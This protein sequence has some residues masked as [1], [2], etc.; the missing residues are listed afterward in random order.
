MPRQWTYPTS[1]WG[2]DEIIDDSIL[3]SLE[4]VP[5]G[6]YGI[7]IGVYDSIT[8]ERLPLVDGTGASI[9]DGRLI[10]PEVIKID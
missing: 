4:D 6:E 3:I 1:L 8:G 9:Q 10:L 5:P 7:A 2:L